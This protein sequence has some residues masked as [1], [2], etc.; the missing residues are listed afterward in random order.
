M[1]L[2]IVAQGDGFGL[3][4]VDRRITIDDMIRSDINPINKIRN[5]SSENFHG[6]LMFVE[7][8]DPSLEKMIPG[9]CFAATYILDMAL[10]KSQDGKSDTVV[11]DD[12]NFDVF[13]DNFHK[14]FSEITHKLNG[15]DN[16]AKPI[17]SY[18]FYDR[19]SGFRKGIVNYDGVFEI[20]TP[21]F[22]IG[23]GARYVNESFK[24]KDDL[25]DM[26]LKTLLFHV[27]NSY[28]LSRHSVNVGGTF[29]VSISDEQGLR[30][31]PKRKR[32]AMNILSGTYIASDI[33]GE[34]LFLGN[35]YETEL[36]DMF[37]KIMDNKNPEMVYSDISII[38]GVSV[39]EH[40]PSCPGINFF[41]EKAGGHSD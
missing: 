17:F 37:G 8:P 25:E 35:V 15:D 22:S 29:K 30:I 2:N 12:P 34:N 11:V 33:T 20:K 10:A 18:I 6:S 16:R 32:V 26:D 21:T 41:M 23:E 24:D 19:K 14:Y 27:S 3:A 31:L 38:T 7:T 28:M 36:I 9:Y 4:A 1:S 13:F 39:D 40:R 5:I